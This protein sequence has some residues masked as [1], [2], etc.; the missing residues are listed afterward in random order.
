LVGENSAADLEPCRNENFE[1]VALY[2]TRDWGEYCKASSPV[3]RCWRKDN[4][5]S[6][7][8]LLMTGLWVERQPNQVAALGNVPPLTRFRCQPDRQFLFR[9]GDFA[10]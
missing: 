5:R 7:P 6:S 4:R 1:R 3:V 2:S 8:G 9:Y 10:E